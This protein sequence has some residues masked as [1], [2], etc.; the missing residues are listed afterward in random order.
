MKKWLKRI[1]WLVLAVAV[2]AQLAPVERNNP[3]VDPRIALALPP[4]VAPLLRAS[5]FDCHS[6]ETRWPWYTY[7]APLSWFISQHVHEARE[8]MNFS[9]WGDYN[10][11]KQSDLLGDIGDVITDGEMPLPSY[12]QL[13]PEAR[14]TPAQAQTIVRWSDAAMQAAEAHAAKNAATN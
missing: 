14:L 10:P 9:T 3:P 1:A 12:L 2:G 6:N 5:C 7:V 8:H 4:D 11:Q 13:H